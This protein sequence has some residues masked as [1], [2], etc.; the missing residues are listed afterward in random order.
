MIYKY[1]T[2]QEQ[3]KKIL[4]LYIAYQDDWRERQRQ[5]GRQI[6]S[7]PDRDEDKER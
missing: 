6:D 1:E 5:A 4:T 3:V 7:Q 2:R